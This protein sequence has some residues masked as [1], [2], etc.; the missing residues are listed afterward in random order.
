MKACPPRRSHAPC[1]FWRR[2]DAW[3][4]SI[5]GGASART[6]ARGS[7]KF[8]RRSALSR[9]RALRT[10]RAAMKSACGGRA[11]SRSIPETNTGET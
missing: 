7:W 4:A 3:L 6:G 9:L 10:E 1:Q 5:D 2:R 11:V 8:P